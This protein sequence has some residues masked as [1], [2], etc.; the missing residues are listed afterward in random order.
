M[1]GWGTLP[2]EP[3]RAWGGRRSALT[4][5][6]YRVDA[7]FVAIPIG[8]FATTGRT[9]TLAPFVAV[10]WAGGRMPG[11]PWRPS[12]ALRP[13]AGLALEWF[14]HLLRLESGVSLRTGRVGVTV[15]LN[16]DWWGIL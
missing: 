5:L 16:R 13:V 8:A 12:G 14:H 1:G 4:S 2:G 9:I 6:E 10:G 3:F 15:D 11:L 7:P